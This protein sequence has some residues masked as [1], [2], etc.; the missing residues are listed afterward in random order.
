MVGLNT[1]KRWWMITIPIDNFNLDVLQM[2]TDFT[3][4][5]TYL[6]GQ[7]E[8]GETGYKHWQMVLYLHD[9][10]RFN[11]VRK[12][13]HDSAHI[14]PVDNIDAS[15]DYVWKDDTHIIGTKFEHGNSFIL[16]LL[17]IDHC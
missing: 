4:N 12:Y 7:Q 8:M 10:K 6:R 11:T 3:K 17:S 15:L 2:D 13:F 16:R 5:L 9:K 1:Q 14:E